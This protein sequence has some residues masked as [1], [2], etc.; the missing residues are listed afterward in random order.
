MLVVSLQILLPL[1]VFGME[2]RYIEPFR[3]RLV[4]CLKEFTKNALSL[5][6]HKSPLGATPTL[7]SLRGFIWI[8]RWAS[9]SLLYGSPPGN[10]SFRGIFLLRPVWFPRVCVVLYSLSLAE[11]VGPKGTRE[12][13]EVRNTLKWLDSNN[14]PF[15]T[16]V[17]MNDRIFHWSGE[18]VQNVIRKCWYCQEHSNSHF[19]L[20]LPLCTFSPCFVGT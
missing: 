12:R 16:Q 6:T 13:E 18:G 8:F 7:V 1:R 3:Y 17:K 11:I 2:S 14:E 19:C 20:Y 15:K 10:V 5:T 9:P 4:L